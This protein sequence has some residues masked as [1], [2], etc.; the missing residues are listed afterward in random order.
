MKLPTAIYLTLGV[1]GLA[2]TL[3]VPV[4]IYR[5]GSPA[6]P[7]WQTVASPGPL[8]AAHAFLGERC[9]SCHTPNKPIAAVSCITCH[10]PEALLLGKQSTS[11]HSN[12]EA[13]AGCHVEHRGAATR[14]VAMVHSVLTAAGFKAAHSGSLLGKSKTSET[15]ALRHYLAGITGDETVADV[16]T[17]DCASCHAFRD[18]HKGLFGQNC[19]DCHKTETWKITGYLHPSSKSEECVQCHQAPPSH[20][21]MHFEMMDKMISGQKNAR[22]E[23]CFACHQTD[24]F[25]NIKGAGWVKVH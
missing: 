16:Q 15:L 10:A 17:L 6:L 21:M 23:Q 9:E 12:I 20:Y 19:A 14:P 18:R 1:L 22:V 7:I 25:N 3:F 2:A 11:F 24:S 5:S 8:S 13:C 4:V